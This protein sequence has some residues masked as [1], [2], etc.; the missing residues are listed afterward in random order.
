[1]NENFAGDRKNLTHFL[2]RFERMI[3]DALVPLVPAWINT[4]HLTLMTLAWSV[5]I[6]ACGYW[7][8]LNI[9]WLWGFNAFILLQYLTDM[10]DGEVGRRRN[11]GLIKWGFYMD[12]FLDYVFLCAITA[13]YSFLLPRSFDGLV[14]LSLAAAGGFMV[15][16]FLDFAITKDFKISFGWFGVSEMRHTLII[17]NALVVFFGKALLVNVFPVFTAV[18]CIGLCAAVYRSQKFY[19]QKDMMLKADNAGPSH[20]QMAAAAH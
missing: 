18:L 10:L 3:I 7:A 6:M 2:L 16:T 5:L 4:A 14:L 20:G 11:T 12:H 8:N 1:M 17:F 15:H 13:G 19:G 9:N